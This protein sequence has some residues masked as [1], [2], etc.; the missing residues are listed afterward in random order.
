MASYT[1]RKILDSDECCPSQQLGRVYGVP[2]NYSIETFLEEA[3]EP[4]K[5]QSQ[6]NYKYLTR[7]IHFGHHTSFY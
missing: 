5:V 1:I 3:N 4:K 2:R 6:M 7:C